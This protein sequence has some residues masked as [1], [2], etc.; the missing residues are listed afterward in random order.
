MAVTKE[1]LRHLFNKSK[2]GSQKSPKAQA[3]GRANKSR[4]DAVERRVEALLVDMG[5]KMVEKV[6][7]PWKNI[8]KGG[9]PVPT[10]KVSGDF[11][12]FT[13]MGYSMLSEVKSRA[14]RLPWSALKPHQ[15]EALNEHA[16]YSAH[17]WL[18]FHDT[19]T[20]RISKFRWPAEGFGPRKSLKSK[21]ENKNE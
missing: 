7:T 21:K 15:A 5:Y 11:R 6:N 19:E 4:G 8:W 1:G 17:T 13:K 14:S 18:F 10:S 9:K 16:K 3:M 2:A 12:G 20:D